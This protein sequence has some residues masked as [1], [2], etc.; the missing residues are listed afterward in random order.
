MY[1]GLSENNSLR[2]YMGS[3]AGAAEDVDFGTASGNTIGKLHLTIQSIPKMTL[4]NAGNVGIGTTAPGYKLDVAGRMRLQQSGANTAGLWLDGQTLPTRSFIGTLNDDHVG[5]YGNG[6]AGWNFVMNVETGNTGIGTSSPTAK[7]D[8]NGTLRFRSSFPK[9]GSVL[10]SDDTNGNAS[11]ADPVAFK[12]SGRN[13]TN[14]PSFPLANWTKWWFDDIAEYNVGFAFQPLQAQFVA[15]E[16]GIYHFNT[17][18]QLTGFGDD[19][20]IRLR[21]DR[22]GTQSTLAQHDK[23]Y[24]L[25]NPPD[26]TDII[27]IDATQL[28][29][30]V[31]LLAGDI[32]WVEMYFNT[33]YNNNPFPPS[34]SVSKTWF[35]GH[36]VARL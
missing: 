21:L 8:V 4:D 14:M 26:L 33:S 2:G 23:N 32:V 29:T 28:S 24:A 12:V 9:K 27:F 1:V 22:G 13:T 20:S 30:D 19:F 34:S 36:L 3:Y 16:D 18:V 10:T 17:Q 7:L 35:S 6:G 5:I 31:K 15:A 25:E 11:W